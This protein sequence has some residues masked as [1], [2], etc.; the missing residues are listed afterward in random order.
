MFAISLT[1]CLYLS[2]SLAINLPLRHDKYLWSNRNYF[3]SLSLIKNGN[4]RLSKMKTIPPH[5]SSSLSSPLPPQPLRKCIKNIWTAFSPLGD[6]LNCVC[7][8]AL[9][10]KWRLHSFYLL[11]LWQKAGESGGG[12]GGLTAYFTCHNDKDSLP[13]MRNMI[14]RK[15]SSRKKRNQVE[16]VLSFSFVILWRMRTEE[17]F[18]EL[19]CSVFSPSSPPPSLPFSF[20]SMLSDRQILKASTS[21]WRVSEL[22]K[23]LVLTWLWLP[24]S[25]H[26]NA[27]QIY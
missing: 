20:C 11:D 18:R 16:Q 25:G 5:A 12:E 22:A 10:R 24:L 2:L 23:Q 8:K 27:R 9:P 21:T 4:C 19:N 1:P 3:D 13:E 6:L 14:A 17:L 26:L 7:K 15:S